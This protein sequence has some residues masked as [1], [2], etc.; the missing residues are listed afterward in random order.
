MRR[1]RRESRE[2]LAIARPRRL[3]VLCYGNI[4]RSPFVAAALSRSAG[5]EV[6][7]AGF[8][9]RIGRETPLEFQ[10]M[11]KRYGIE[12]APHRSRLIDAATVA[13][14]DVI[15]VMDRHNWDR[16][17]ESWPDTLTK[18][19]W[20]G[21]FLDRGSVEIV[22]PYGRDVV[23]MTA[24]AERLHRASQALARRLA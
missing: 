1:A 20:L 19:V 18:T 5:I 13:W 2:R 3:L 10:Q 9:A 4:Y 7:S 16:L 23:E 12:L 21:G 8:H 15:V 24:I 22:D 11:A 17:R 14:A 6:R